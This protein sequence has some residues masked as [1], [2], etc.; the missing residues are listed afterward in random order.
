VNANTDKVEQ[1][2]MF[3]LGKNSYFSES[4]FVDDG[5][6]DRYWGKNAMNLKETK[7]K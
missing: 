2:E 6:I 4:S 1:S 5:Y 3:K 7:E